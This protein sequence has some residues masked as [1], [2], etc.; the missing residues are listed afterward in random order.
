MKAQLFM[1][2]MALPEKSKSKPESFHRMIWPPWTV[3]AITPS[4]L[5][6][7]LSL[8]LAFPAFGQFTNSQLKSFCFADQ[9]GSKPYARLLQSTDGVLYGTTYSGGGAVQGTGLQDKQG[10]KRLQCAAKLCRHWRRR[11]AALRRPDCRKR[12][13]VIRHD[14]VRRQHKSRHGLQD[15]QG[16]K[17]LQCAAK[18]YRHWRRRA[19]PYAGLIEGKDGGLSAQLSLAEGQIREPSSD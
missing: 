12:W 17:R 11:G 19:Q 6:I 1:N 18:L 3:Q 14:L 15:K 16:R 9:L 5:L 13:C 4:A 8:F 2:T 7:V 10:R